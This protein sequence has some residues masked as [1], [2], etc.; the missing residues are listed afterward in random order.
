MRLYDLALPPQSRGNPDGIPP[1]LIEVKKRQGAKS[2]G[3]RSVHTH[4]GP[5]APCAVNP[6]CHRWR[7]APSVPHRSRHPPCIGILLAI[8]LCDSLA[9]FIQVPLQHYRADQLHLLP[10]VSR[11][12]HGIWMHPGAKSRSLA[13]HRCIKARIRFTPCPSPP[14]AKISSMSPPGTA[15]RGGRCSQ[16]CA[17]P[18]RT[19][20]RGS[21]AAARTR[22]TERAE[23][24]AAHQPAAD[25]SRS[26]QEPRHLDSHRGRHLLR[27]HGGCHRHHC[28]LRH[29]RA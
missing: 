11:G 10:D 5:Y 4:T 27:G 20:F 22:W 13:P 16:S 14:P 17:P 2:Y 8:A 1:L 18:L 26:I 29:R 3:M 7:G 12:G 9:K 24:R 19:D 6:P 28:H 21:G 23:G 15:S 25:F